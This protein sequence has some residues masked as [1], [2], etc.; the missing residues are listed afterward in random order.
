MNNGTCNNYP[1]TWNCTCPPEWK[2]LFCQMGKIFLAFLC[3]RLTDE[4]LSSLFI[5][6]SL[7]LSLK[8]D[9][10]NQSNQ[11]KK[12]FCQMNMIVKLSN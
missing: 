12:Y 4:L 1:G 2:G 3:F 11:K 5:L 6:Y 8:N 10:A 7:E 9:Q